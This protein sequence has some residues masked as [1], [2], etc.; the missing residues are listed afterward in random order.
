MTSATRNIIPFRTTSNVDSCQASQQSIFALAQKLIRI[1]S[2]PR[3]SKRPIVSA[4]HEWFE[5]HGMQS[6]IL[7]ARPNYSDSAPLGVLVEIGKHG[8]GPTICITGCLDTAPI[9]DID[10]W[11]HDPLSGV[12]ANGRIW[13]RG[14]ADSKVMVSIFA[15]IVRELWK[16]SDNLEAHIVFLA[17]ADEHNGKFRAITQL[18]KRFPETRFAFIGYPG[19]KSIRVGSRGFYRAK[20]KIFGKTGHSGSRYKNSENAVVKAASLVSMIDAIDFPVEQDIH[21]SFGPKATVTSINGGGDFTNVPNYCELAVDVRLTPN[22]EKTDAWALL[23]KLRKAV[24]KKHPGEKSTHLEPK[25]S[26][27]SYRLEEDNYYVSLLHSAARVELG[28]DVK[29]EVTGPSNVGNYLF[30]KG[31]PATSGFGVRYEGLHADNECVELS[32]VPSTYRIY[33]RVLAEISGIEAGFDS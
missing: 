25:G 15:H 33:S 23:E 16:A 18:I 10:G 5:S 13:G 29:L 6:E 9:Y 27:P 3:S 28:S 32:S 31:I 24:D 1:N 4:M 19:D 22:F 2:E 11:K 12:E 26:W 17:D 7:R 20:F 8:R 21:F 30:Q 14:S